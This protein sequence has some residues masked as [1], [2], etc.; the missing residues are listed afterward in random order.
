MID[1]D[2]KSYFD[3]INDDKLMILIEQRLSDRRVLKL[4]QNWLKTGVLSEGKREKT[5]IGSAQGGVISP[6]CANIYLNVLDNLWEKHGK[7][8]GKPV[9][10][11]E[12]HEKDETSNQRG[13]RQK[14]YSISRSKSGIICGR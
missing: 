8:Y 1:A 3:N 11:Q 2:I 4:I 13:F 7:P 12:V 10:E 14:K 5:E 9:S 6:L